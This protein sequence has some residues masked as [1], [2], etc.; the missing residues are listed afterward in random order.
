MGIAVSNLVNI[1]NPQLIILG[2]ELPKAGQQVLEAVIEEM[3]K[4]ILKEFIGTVR[5]VRSSLKEEPSLMGAYALAL[6]AL[7]SIEKWDI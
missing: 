3:N 4:R 5:V 1:F 7:F 2:G 6:D